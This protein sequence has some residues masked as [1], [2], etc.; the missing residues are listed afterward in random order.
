MQKRHGRIRAAGK[1]AFA[2]LWSGVEGKGLV[3]L[4]EDAKKTELF[5]NMPIPKAVMQLAI[6]TVI[7]SLVMVIYNLADTYFV[8]MLNDPIQNAAVTLAAPVLLAFNAINN[9][10][11]VGSS[12][13]MSRALGSKDMDTVYKSSAFGF[14]CAL[15][16]GLLFSVLYTVFSA[17]LLVV[18]GANAETAQATG[19][20]L[21][22]TVSFGAAPAILNVVMAYLVRAEGA[23]LHASIGTMSGCL[24]NILLDPIFV[25][26]WGLNLGAAG[27][28][29]ATFI[30]N[31]VACLYF[32]VLLFVRRG[33]TYVCI[34]PRQF[35]PTMRIVRGVCGVGIPASIQ[36]LLNVTGMTVLNNFAASFGSDAV[37]AMGIAQKIN[38][39]PFQVALG[40]SQGIMPLISYNYASGNT[41]RM[42][43]TF[44]FTA[45]IS[46]SFLFLVMIAYLVFAGDLVRMF[47]DNEQIVAYGTSFLRGMCI[48]MPFLCMDFLAVGVFQ[49]C[50]LGKEAFIFA[51]LRK[52]VLEIPAL[53]ILNWL[54]P[55]Y[56][57]AYAQ[58]VA[59]VILAAAAIIVL[60][61]P[62][63]RLERHQYPG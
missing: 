59:E 49:A 17:P 15:F 18:L 32:F 46:L 45:R 55:L 7:S 1:Q 19:G 48:A 51:V 53:F 47:M 16:S 56:G 43:K 33:R 62:F 42:K 36:N 41:R 25:L 12:S 60:A 21:M 14:Y 61:R 29:C 6:P 44:F 4:M 30:S 39:V 27:A 3:I 11:G 20:Y 13:M 8:G 34:N 37:A 35:R 23:S 40:I 10:F 24:L 31:C 50:G 57:L 54:F 2:R 63:R 28:G 58:L 5:E 52:I 22:W 9:L 38:T 26:P